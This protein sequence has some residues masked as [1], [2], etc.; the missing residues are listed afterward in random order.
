[1]RKPKK[2]ATSVLAR[3]KVAKRM[4]RKGHTFREIGNR[5]GVTAQ[6]AWKMVGR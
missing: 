3:E 6:A 1:M 5:L 4:R 2:D